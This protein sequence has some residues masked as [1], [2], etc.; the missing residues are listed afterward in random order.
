[1][2][3][4]MGGA[5]PAAAAAP[6]NDDF[7]NAT[8]IPGVPF[9]ATLDTSEATSDADPN[10]E[11]CSGG[12]GSVWYTFTP[13]YFGDWDVVDTGSDYTPVFTWFATEPFLYPFSCG[14]G[15]MRQNLLGGVTYYLQV[16]GPGGHLEFAV[17]EPVYTE[18]TV[19][20][21]PVATL[22][23]AASS[24]VTVSDTVACTLDGL[25]TIDGVISQRT[26]ATMAEGT[27]GDQ[28]LLNIPCTSTPTAWS[29]TVTGDRFLA[30]PATV[31]VTASACDTF[32]NSCDY[33][34]TA[35]RTVT[36]RR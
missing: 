33:S 6:A 16:A 12:T 24:T 27:F 36:I 7:A 14:Q 5:T 13:P 23:R 30:K 4:V 18:L 32:W 10:L 15:I 9:S 21:D 26:G 3:A 8:P 31:T 1:M 2:V 28:G 34:R 20:I 17:Q 11:G 29:R 25:A 19:T 35:T 22:G